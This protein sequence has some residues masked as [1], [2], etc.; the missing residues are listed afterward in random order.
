MKEFN[1]N[2]L[3][4][5]LQINKLSLLLFLRDPLINEFNNQTP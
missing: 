1:N 2:L 5:I 3:I 4:N